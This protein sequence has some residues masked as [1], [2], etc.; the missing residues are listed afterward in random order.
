MLPPTTTVHHNLSETS[1]KSSLPSQTPVTIL[2]H[3]QQTLPTSSSSPLPAVQPFHLFRQRPLHNFPTAINSLLRR[4]PVFSHCPVPLLYR[5]CVT[6]EPSDEVD[7]GCWGEVL[8]LGECCTFLTLWLWRKYTVIEC[9]VAHH[10]CVYTS[11]SGTIRAPERKSV[12]VH[13]ASRHPGTDVIVVRQRVS[14]LESI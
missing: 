10:A 2:H 13:R 5:E 4:S 8:H 12:S 7:P 3:S 14:M 6:A 9:M 11:V 1:S